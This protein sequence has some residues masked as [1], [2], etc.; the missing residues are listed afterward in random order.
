VTRPQDDPRQLLEASIT[1]AFRGEAPRSKHAVR[2]GRAPGMSAPARKVGHQPVAPERAS[3]QSR[4]CSGEHTG[5][6]LASPMRWRHE[7]TVALGASR[8]LLA[9]NAPSY[10]KS[11]MTSPKALGAW[12]K[13]WAGTRRLR[14]PISTEA[15]C[16]HLMTRLRVDTA[17]KTSNAKR[18][19]AS[20]TIHP[21]CY[22]TLRHQVSGSGGPAPRASARRSP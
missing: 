22:Q 13:D 15:N 8:E 2:K 12:P 10:Q 20:G 21:D 4:A 17:A 19:R 18:V 5:K 3:T 11:G 1:Q 6:A 16:T 7:R 14:A 9:R